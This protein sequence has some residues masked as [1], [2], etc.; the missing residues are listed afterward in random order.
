[1]T[2]SIYSRL[3][4]DSSCS[5][6]EMTPFYIEVKTNPDDVEKIIEIHPDINQLIELIDRMIIGK[7]NPSDTL[8][9]GLYHFA[10]ESR[11]NRAAS[12]VLSVD[13]WNFIEA[14]NELAS[15]SK[16]EEYLYPGVEACP[17]N[18]DLDIATNAACYL[19]QLRNWAVGWKKR[20]DMKIAEIEKQYS[21]AKNNS[22]E[23]D[24]VY[25]AISTKMAKLG[26]PCNQ[27]P[28]HYDHAITKKHIT[29][30]RDWAIIMCK[31][32]G[33]IEPAPM[34]QSELN[35]YFKTLGHLNT[36]YTIKN[37]RV[38]IPKL[39][40]LSQELWKKTGIIQEGMREH[41]CKHQVMGIFNQRLRRSEVDTIENSV[42][43]EALKMSC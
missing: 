14:I 38:V 5:A 20:F 24:K 37:K 35:T 33:A 31:K 43:R 2:S 11:K 22:I 17:L 19:I 4:G 41:F 21:E 18:E 8:H 27:L 3:A 29:E 10:V 23:A 40:E 1:M 42:L 9:V 6:T 36:H 25:H 39:T 13:A 28:L 16:M 7:K 32:V 15:K 12:D 30:I 26:I 34:T